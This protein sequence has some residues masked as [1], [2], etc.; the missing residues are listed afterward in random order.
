MSRL[1]NIPI[2]IKYSKIKK[3]ETLCTCFCEDYTAI[4]VA[5]KLNVS[6]QTINHYY[7]IL[8][9][10]I[11]DECLI[12]DSHLLDKLLIQN[13]IHIKYLNIYQEDIFYI[14]DK[15]SIL[16]LDDNI[17]MKAFNHFI[18]QHIKEPLSKHKKANCVRVLF[19]KHNHSYLISGYLTQEDNFSSF[20]EERLKQFRGINKEKLGAYIKESQIRFNLS[21]S[22]LNQKLIESFL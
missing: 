22:T 19:N 13:Q 3:I 6:R 21:K 5:K 15:G 2:R 12:F 11:L 9:K 8:R 1:E 10:K 18:Q 17:Q 14:E 4:E 7:K 16:I 20:L